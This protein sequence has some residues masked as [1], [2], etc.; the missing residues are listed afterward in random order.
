MSWL[1]PSLSLD[2]GT[3]AVQHEELHCFSRP[4]KSAL[5]SPVRETEGTL[6]IRVVMGN[7]SIYLSWAGLMDIFYVL[8]YFL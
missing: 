7:E 5:A 6:L 8:T 1:Y 2:Y 4:Q 3:S